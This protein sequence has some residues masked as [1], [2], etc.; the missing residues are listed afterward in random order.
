[1]SGSQDVEPGQPVRAQLAATMN[2]VKQIFQKVKGKAFVVET[3]FDGEDLVSHPCKTN[4]VSEAMTLYLR[5][6]YF[7]FLILLHGDLSMDAGERMQIHHKGDMFFYYSRNGLDHGEQSGYTIFNR[8][9]EKQVQGHDY[10]LDCELV[11]WN[12]KEQASPL[13]K[14]TY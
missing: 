14:A 10:I 12:K 8:V 7:G 4:S 13:L 2:G 9:L 6:L 5:A 1:M 3:K 11:A